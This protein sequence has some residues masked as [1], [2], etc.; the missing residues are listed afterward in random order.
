MAIQRLELRHSQIAS[1]EYIFSSCYDFN[2]G[3]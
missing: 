1:D 3:L 2:R